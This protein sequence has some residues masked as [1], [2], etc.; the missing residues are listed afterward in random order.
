MDNTPHSRFRSGVR[1]PHD[2]SFIV[3]EAEPVDLHAVKE[4]L[5]RAI[6]RMDEQGIRQWDE[7]YP[8][9]AILTGDIERRQMFV[10]AASGGIIAG[11]VVINEEE[12]AEY[13]NVAWNF[14]GKVAVVH[15]LTIDPCF[16]RKGFATDLMG[17]AE[18]FGRE[19]GYDSVR[20][21]AFT[22]NPAAVALYAKRGYRNAGT[23]SFRKG[24]FFCFEKK[25]KLS[26]GTDLRDHLDLHGR[27]KR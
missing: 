21:D 7:I 18:D 23:V 26:P 1:T 8:S 14:P 13:A 11:F 5:R 17:F 3:R 2:G 16:Q 25:I 27:T 19:N 24:K 22:L 6:H 9:E 4:V 20:L 15:R 10:I 12:S